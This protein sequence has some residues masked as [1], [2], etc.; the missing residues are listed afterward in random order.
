MGY[1]WLFKQIRHYLATGEL[2]TEPDIKERVRVCRLHLEKSVELKGEKRG[3]VEM[4]KFYGHYFKGLPDIKVY[5]M[6]LVTLNN[7]ED[8]TRLLD[9][10]SRE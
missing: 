10:I 6:K 4:R 2:L 3:V 5:R 9:K 1:P 8:I 7:K